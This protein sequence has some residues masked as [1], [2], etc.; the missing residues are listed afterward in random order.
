MGVLR[1]FDGP[2]ALVEQLFLSNPVEEQLLAD[3]R[4]LQS[5]AATLGLGIRQWIDPQELDPPIFSDIPTQRWDDQATRI[6][7]ALLERGIFAGY[8]DGTFRPDQ[9]IT[10]LE[11]AAALYRLLAVKGETPWKTS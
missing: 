4:V 9:P 11:C 8:P 1:S 7:A 2:A 6:L 5:A 10:L 3:N